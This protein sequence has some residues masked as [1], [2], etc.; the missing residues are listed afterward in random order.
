MQFI[1]TAAVR[2]SSSLPTKY[3]AGNKVYPRSINFSIY[4]L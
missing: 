2:E 1:L 3:I 4:K